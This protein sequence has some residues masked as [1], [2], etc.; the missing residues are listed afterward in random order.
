MNKN[1]KKQ[2]NLN[3]VNIRF[4]D[5]T[6]VDEAEKVINKIKNYKCK[7]EDR[8]TTSKLRKLLA[9]TSEIYDELRANGIDAVMDKIVYL[10]IQFVYQ[11]G[12]YKGMK[13]FIEQAQLIEILKKIQQ[14]KDPKDFVPICNPLKATI[15]PLISIFEKLIIIFSS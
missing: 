4:K 15:S 10:Q 2:N 3:V 8:V 5:E 1:Q 13:N 6:Y 14:S 9:L 12:R 7:K 11:G